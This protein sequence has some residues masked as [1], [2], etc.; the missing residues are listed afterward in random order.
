MW[1][2]GD[3]EE[4]EGVEG[5][6]GDHDDGDEGKQGNVRAD[7]E[8]PRETGRHPCCED[9]PHVALTTLLQGSSG[10]HC[11]ARRAVS[12]SDVFAAAV[13]TATVAAAAAAAAAPVRGRNTRSIIHTVIKW[14]G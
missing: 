6:G 4:G 5:E 7:V 3:G 9:I 13:A 11:P 14:L 10:K 1:Y 2:E 12:F 8:N